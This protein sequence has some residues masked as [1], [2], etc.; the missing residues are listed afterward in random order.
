MISTVA[1]VYVY[2]CILHAEVGGTSTAYI[3][4]TLFYTNKWTYYDMSAMR[5]ND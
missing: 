1:P 4:D 3:N 5:G 2:F